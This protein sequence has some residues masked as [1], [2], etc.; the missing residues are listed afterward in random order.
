M[1]TIV[2]D[3]KDDLCPCNECP[4]ICRRMLF[5][6]FCA[7]SLYCDPVTGRPYQLCRIV[8]GLTGGRSINGTYLQC[9]GYDFSRH[10]TVSK[11]VGL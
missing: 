7:K 2:H 10:A 11:K 8:R 1:Q 6:P 9:L 3:S 5:A 4:Y